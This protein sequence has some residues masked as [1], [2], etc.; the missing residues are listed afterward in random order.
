MVHGIQDHCRTWDAM[1]REL[2]GDHHVVAPDLRGHGD[3]EWLRGSAYQYL[4][5][6]YDVHQ[7]I[8]QANLAPVTLV[9]HSLGGAICALFAGVYPELVE[10]LIVIEGIGLYVSDEIPDT[11]S[12]RIRNW[13]SST[14]GLAARI[15]RRY[16]DLEDAYKRMQEANP[17][18]TEDQALHLTVHGS[19]QNEDGTYSWKF[20]NYT[21]NFTPSNLNHDETREVWRNITAPVLI[22]N[23]EHGLEHRIGQN[24]TLKEFRD[25]RLEVVPD[26]EHWTYHD[27]PEIVVDLVRNF[28][29]TSCV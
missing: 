29:D 10:R 20:D 1:A 25:V 16:P 12:G 27:Q 11:P 7:L 19:N 22:I 28:L 6:V 18:L 2:T 3:S 4:D 26:A 9:G 23:A 15:P 8:V 14:R 17:Q 24:D 5:Y 21:F 13:I